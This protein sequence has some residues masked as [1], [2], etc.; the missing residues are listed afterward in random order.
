M[1]ISSLAKPTA[2]ALALTFCGTHYISAQENGSSQTSAAEQADSA[3]EASDNDSKKDQEAKVC[4][5]CGL[6]VEAKQDDPKGLKVTDVKPDSAADKA[7][8]KKGDTLVSISDQQIDSADE[9]HK[10]MSDQQQKSEEAKVNV[11]LLR[12]EEEQQVTLTLQSQDAQ[13]AAREQAKKEA[14]AKED[15]AKKDQAEKDAQADQEQAETDQKEAMDDEKSSDAEQSDKA[16]AGSGEDSDESNDGKEKN[17][18]DKKMG[19]AN[20]QASIGVTLDPSPF[21]VGEGVRISSVYTNGPA[22]QAGLKTGDRI[23]KVDGKDISSVKDLQDSVDKMDPDHKAKFT[24]MVDGEKDS[25]EIVVA[26]KAETIKRAMVE[27]QPSSNQSAEAFNADQT[28][29]QTLTEIRDELRDLRQ[30]V[31]AMENGDKDGDRR[32]EEET[33]SASQDQ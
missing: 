24:V 13:Q 12:D 7:G 30:R 10:L 8:I 11:K 27:N 9:M 31:D 16:D 20:K 2:A 22:Q 28:L 6:R 26:S 23:L 32:D 18:N 19:D 14:Q 1:K 25:V 33:D 17:D 15:Q 21:Q 29:S 5:I 3:N 4:P